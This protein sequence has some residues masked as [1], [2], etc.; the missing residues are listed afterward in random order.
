MSENE[1]SQVIIA[2]FTSYSTIIQGEILRDSNILLR[3]T[4]RERYEIL[5]YGQTVI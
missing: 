5:I 4:D 2:F 1:I 3:E